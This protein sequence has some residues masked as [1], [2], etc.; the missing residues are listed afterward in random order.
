MPLALAQ[1]LHRCNKRQYVLFA[2]PGPELLPALA[3]PAV[4]S[5]AL[6]TQDR[7]PCKKRTEGKQA[8]SVSQLPS[9]L[10]CHADISSDKEIGIRP[11]ACSESNDGI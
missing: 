5:V 6:E 2:M 3:I 8:K 10:S 7:D 4:D 9:R 1:E 11:L